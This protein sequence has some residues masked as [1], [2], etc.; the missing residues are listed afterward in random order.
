MLVDPCLGNFLFEFLGVLP[1]SI[2][3][4]HIR[5]NNEDMILG[6]GLPPG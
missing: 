5:F 1:G 2:L 4:V 3:I 6:A